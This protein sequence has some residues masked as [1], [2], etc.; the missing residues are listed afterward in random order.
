MTELP[1]HSHD[2]RRWVPVAE[3]AAAAGVSTSAVRRWQHAG[4]IAHRLE[5]GR[6]RA[7]V[8]LD[9]V[10]RLHAVSAGA[11]GR[12]VHDRDNVVPLD[13]PKATA[14]ELRERLERATETAAEAEERA[15]AAEA[16]AEEL[17]L[18]VRE[19]ESWIAESTRFEEVEQVQLGRLLALASAER[20]ARRLPLIAS[21]RTLLLALYVLVV[22]AFIV[23][24]L[25]AHL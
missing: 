25:A 22:V 19:L 16:D 13:A 7:L 12:S 4:R 9:E 15:A 3:A 24:L 5:A 18:R 17:R 21:A 8:D 23:L 14:A 10:L 6:G 11:G 2:A 20:E 1:L